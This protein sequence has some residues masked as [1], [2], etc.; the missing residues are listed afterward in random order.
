MKPIDIIVP[1][2]NPWDPSWM[3]LASEYAGWIPYE[4]VRDL[5]TLRYF[6][7]G[8]DKNMP[9][10]NNVYL[11]LQSESQIPEWL[12]TDNPKLNII[13]HEDYIPK[14]FLPTFN[15]NVIEL[16]YHRIKSLSDHFIIAND[17]TIA[18]SSLEP[19]DFFIDNKVVGGYSECI[20]NWKSDGTLFSKT[21]EN[22]C[23]FTG[24]FTRKN[25]RPFYKSYHLFSPQLK[26]LHEIFWK[27]YEP[28]ILE[29]IA[30]SRLRSEKNISHL[31]FF[32]IAKEIGLY[33]TDPN[34]REGLLRI[35][36]GTNP[37]TLIKILLKQ[38]SKMCCMQD[39]FKMTPDDV[40][41]KIVQLPLHHFLPDKSS[42]EI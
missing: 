32:F 18:I 25:N 22:C 33:E 24:M 21:V 1:F 8:V 3:K 4:R 13:Y 26:G 10:I 39:E 31:V 28:E 29:T 36:D 12:N 5:G 7:R 2:V 14:E 19:S 11:V 9:W 27:K 37:D 42:F 40:A 30:D 6:F 35:K 15:S 34:Y 38:K 20:E 41:R 23:K 17:D 16:F